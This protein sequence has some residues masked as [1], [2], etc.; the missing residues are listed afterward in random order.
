MKTNTLVYYTGKALRELFIYSTS[1]E[2]K[3]SVSNVLELSEK[4]LEE[5]GYIGKVKMSDIA[6]YT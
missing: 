4:E 5:L 3:L 6:S 2:E 1:E